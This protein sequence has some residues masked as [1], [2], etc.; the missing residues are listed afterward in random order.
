MNRVRKSR[1]ALSG[2]KGRKDEIVSRL[3]RAGARAEMGEVQERKRRWHRRRV[4]FIAG[5][6]GNWQLVRFAPLESACPYHR[7]RSH[8][9]ALATS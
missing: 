8:D 6:W 7:F 9:D 2:I 3:G 5:R 1:G 4:G